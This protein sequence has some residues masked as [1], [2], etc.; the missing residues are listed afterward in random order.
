M[1]QQSEYQKFLESKRQVVNKDGFDVSD[2]DLSETLFDFQ[3]HI[4]KKAI[5]A[6]KYAIFSECGTG[7]TIMQLECAKLVSER[8]NKPFL[9]LANLGVSQQTKNE[10]DKFGYKC[11][12]IDKKTDLSKL[13]AGNYITNYEQLKDIDTSFFCG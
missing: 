13:P 8:C 9:T 4:V 10:A 11:E 1:E 6:A 2:S 7:K 3:K 12:R 5:K